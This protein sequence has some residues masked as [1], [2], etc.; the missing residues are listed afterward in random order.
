LPQLLEE[1]RKIGRVLTKD[2]EIIVVDDGSLDDTPQILAAYQKE[3]RELRIITHAVNKGYGYSIRDLYFA[4]AKEWMV[5][6]PADNQIDAKEVLKLVE[7][8]KDAD[9]ILG[10]R[11]I[12]GDHV[13]RRIQSR[14]YNKLLHLLFHIPIT[15]VNTIRLMKGEIIKQIPL[16]YTSPFVDAELII[17]ATYKGYKVI[18]VPILHKARV[19][20]GA[21]GGKFFTSIWPTFKDMMIFFWKKDV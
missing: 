17:R 1:V 13:M 2:L 8:V 21:T 20:A 9:M 10:K 18:E 16:V 19:T 6:L 4:A 11:Q 7:Y 14:T 5:T 3:W 12:R 15:D